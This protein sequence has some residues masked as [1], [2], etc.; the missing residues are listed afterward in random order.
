MLQQSVSRIQS[1]RE[2]SLASPWGLEDS[3]VKQ[4][5]HEQFP[6]SGSDDFRVNEEH[7]RKP[8]SLSACLPVATS[9]PLSEP[10][11]FSLV[12]PFQIHS[13]HRIYGVEPKGDR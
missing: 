12:R 5:T 6:K 2:V 8:V 4:P 7:W 9:A 11:M 1:E 3:I 13:I 10:V